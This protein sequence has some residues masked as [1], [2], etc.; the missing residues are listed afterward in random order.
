M[1]GDHVGRRE[2]DLGLLQREVTFLVGVDPTTVC[3]WQVGTASPNLR[4]RSD[5]DSVDARETTPSYRRHSVFAVANPSV[6]IAA[7]Y[8][9]CLITTTRARRTCAPACIRTK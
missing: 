5:R 2:L 7:D 3:D 6:W 4:V 9:P 8:R 1:I